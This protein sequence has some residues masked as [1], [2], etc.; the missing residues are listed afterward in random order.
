[1]F[2]IF[3]PFLLKAY[4]Y[5]SLPF[6]NLFPIGFLF[7]TILDIIELFRKNDILYQ[8]TT[9]LL[10]KFTE[11]RVYNLHRLFTDKLRCKAIHTLLPILLAGTLV[12][13]NSSKSEPTSL[14]NSTL[15]AEY[16]TDTN[17]EVPLSDS[18][19]STKGTRDN[20]PYCLTP[21]ADGSLT[22]GNELATLDL[23][24]I[25]EGYFMAKYLGSNAK[26]KMQVTGPNGVTYT[27]NLGTDYEVYPFA[28][29]N[30][31]YSVGIHEN[32]T[33][34]QY[35]TICS[36]VIDVTILDEFSPYLYPNQYVNFN[37][38][39]DVVA[40]ASELAYPANDDLTVVTNVY[41]YIISNITYDYEKATTVESGYIPVVDEILVTKK[42]ICFD[43]ASAMASMLRSQHIPT[44]LEIGY[45]GEAYHAWISTYLDEIG[46]VNGI[47]EF[48]GKNWQLMDPTF[49][50]SSSEKNL[51]DFI[52]DGSNYVTKYIY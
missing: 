39:S 43:F 21:M 49:A 47:I 26:V 45:A 23:S 37:A 11:R 15:A 6:G 35:A 8:S 9:Y 10:K 33:G 19:S 30:G 42:G 3:L 51:K 28:S 29:G 16:S 34:T 12:G 14:S 41:N 22:D 13:C 18:S 17:A 24:H 7:A 31:S 25:D 44:R 5:K 1:M 32:I 50:A 40:L 27:Y 2:H 52:G 48:D 20:T 36:T 38:D 46:W 4:I